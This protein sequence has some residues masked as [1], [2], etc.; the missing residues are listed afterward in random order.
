MSYS[1]FTYL[2]E[3]PRINGPKIKQ[4]WKALL[5]EDSLPA[6]IKAEL[7]ELLS[8]KFMVLSDTVLFWSDHVQ[9]LRM[10]DVGEYKTIR[11]KRTWCAH[12][13]PIYPE[14]FSSSFATAAYSLIQL[15]PE[16]AETDRYADYIYKVIFGTTDSRE[17]YTKYTNWT[18]EKVRK[19]V[20]SCCYVYNGKMMSNVM[21][22]SEVYFDNR[23]L[24]DCECLL[25]ADWLDESF[26]STI[27]EEQRRFIA[28]VLKDCDKPKADAKFKSINDVERAHDARTEREVVKLAENGTI[29]LIYNKELVDVSYKFGFRLPKSNI[30]MIKRGKQH[31][32]CVATYFD[33]HKSALLISLMEAGITREISRIFFTDTATLELSIEYC[34]KG[35]ISTR[36]IQY[37]GRF[38]KDAVRDTSLIALRIALVGLPAEILQVTCKEKA[39]EQKAEEA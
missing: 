4:D 8:H 32:N 28:D 37:K 6:S 2:K 13:Y 11:G 10:T 22:F 21:R 5:S 33:K 25:W 7:N 39:H 36:V 30:D 12:Q 20:R 29:E 34:R 3:N 31:N 9:K 16:Q 14:A 15:E 35:I 17:L 18:I 38:N 27:T 24:P 19:L 23:V 1:L 26:L